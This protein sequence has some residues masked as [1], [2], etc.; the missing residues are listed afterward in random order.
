MKKSILSWCDKRLID[1][2]R[3]EI[4]RLYTLRLAV[5]VILIGVLFGLLPLVSDEIKA[6]IGW[7]A[8]SI[9]FVLL[10]VSFGLARLLKQPGSDQ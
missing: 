10:G 4:R 9:L 1:N 2:W 8:F 6:I 7:K 3:T 5:V